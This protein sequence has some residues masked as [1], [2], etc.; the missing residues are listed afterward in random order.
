ML[1]ARLEHGHVLKKLVDVV[2]L[3]VG[4]ANFDVSSDGITLQAMDSSHVALVSIALHAKGFE[5]FKCDRN[6]SLGINLQSF[7]KILKCASNEDMITIKAA[8]NA[9]VVEFTFE[10]PKQTR[11]SE[12]QLKLMDIDS[13]S[14]EIPSTPYKCIVTLPSAEFQRI[15]REITIIGDSVK[16]SANKEGVTFS[17]DG[18]LGSG[19][20]VLRP[21]NGGGD[22]GMD[23][24]DGDGSGT[25]AK[26]T[27][28]LEEDVSLTFA[29]RYLNSFAKAT[30]LASSVTLKMSPDVPLVV[31]YTMES[32]GRVAFYVAPQA[33]E[34][35]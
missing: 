19:N 17:V 26:T 14:L 29:L 18:D 27:I 9:D 34:V 25:D 28:N 11:L 20:V 2:C 21:T 15:C 5:H 33:E 1:E 3:L 35:D 24:G 4:E 13:E 16:I 22:D 10:S 23:M 8:D 6:M 32:L 30:T 7:S 31:E 12:F